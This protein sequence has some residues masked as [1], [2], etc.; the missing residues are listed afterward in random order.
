MYFNN[1]TLNIITMGGLV[2]A[3]GRIV[4]DS[5]VVLENIY[6]HLE[7]GEPIREAAIN[8]TGELAM[9]I[10]AVTLTTMCV[11]FPIIFVGGMVSTIFT[12]MSLVV[13]FG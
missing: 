3:I 5:V 8:A 11:F 2:L 10:T 13:M 1:M 12:P 9:A 4:D 6:R 7:E